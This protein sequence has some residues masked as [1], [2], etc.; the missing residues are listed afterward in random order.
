MSSIQLSLPVLQKSNDASVQ[1]FTHSSPY[2]PGPYTRTPPVPRSLPYVPSLAWFCLQRMLQVADQVSDTMVA[3]LKYQPPSS[4]TTYDLI[5]A[6]IPTLNTPEFDWATVDPRLWAALVQIYD[7][8]PADF[9]SYEIPLA[10]RH[11]QLLQQIKSTSTPPFSVVTILELPGC[12][13]LSDATIVNLKHLHSLCALDASGSPLSAQGIKT[14]SGTI[15]WSDEDQTRKGPWGLRILRLRNCRALN[16]QVFQHLSP[17]LLLSVLDLRGTRCNSKTVFPTFQPAPPETY[18]LY[19]PRPLRH[20]IDDLSNTYQE[21]FSS[22]NVF[23]LYINTLHHPMHAERRIPQPRLEDVT[24]T[25]NPGSSDFVLGSTPDEAKPHKRRRGAATRISSNPAEDDNCSPVMRHTHPD[26]TLHNYFAAQEVSAHSTAQNMLSFYH[27]PGVPQRPKLSRGYT[28]PPE[29]PSVLSTK[30][31]KLMLY[32]SPPLWS[33]LEATTPSSPRAKAARSEA[34]PVSVKRKRVEMTQYLEELNAKRQKIQEK[35][36]VK[37]PP[38]CP[39]T[40]PLSR[41]PFRR[42]VSMPASALQSSS[43]DVSDVMRGRDEAPESSSTASRCEPTTSTPTT[44]SQNRD[45]PSKGRSKPAFDWSR[46][47]KQ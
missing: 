12:R 4:E 44:G 18:S 29:P 19:N 25:F 3:R 42:K 21:L 38:P 41:N 13:E 16:D 11:L 35:D 32:R 47:G 1:K 14:L 7:D 20:C 37:S 8:L 17:F 46:W 26:M 5:Q 33:V 31:M 43:P 30:D 28:Y 27:S 23:T 15:L 6:L 2:I 45:A 24:V 39:E 36:A 22:P 34:L 10:D 40:A 9:R